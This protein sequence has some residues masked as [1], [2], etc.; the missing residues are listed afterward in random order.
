MHETEEDDDWVEKTP[1]PTRGL[2][3]LVALFGI[4]DEG[5][6]DRGVHEAGLVEMPIT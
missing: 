5:A 2:I 3:V 4:C 6:L 1:L